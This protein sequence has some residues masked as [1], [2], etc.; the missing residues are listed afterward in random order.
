MS[1]RRLEE[2]YWRAYRDFY[3]WGSILRGAGAKQTLR[4]QLRHVT[5]TGAWK[6]AEPIWDAIIRARM[7]GFVVPLMES[8]MAIGRV[9]RTVD[10]PKDQLSPARPGSGENV[11]L[12]GGPVGL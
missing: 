5:Y 2:G 7:L 1:P 8:V 12:S 9:K 4:G 3:S 11:T 6:K 10:A